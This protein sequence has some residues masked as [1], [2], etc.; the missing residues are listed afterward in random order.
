M[1]L[2]VHSVFKVAVLSIFWLI[3]PPLF[4]VF[5]IIWK[6]P[7]LL[8]RIVLTIVAPLSLIAF[9]IGIFGVTQ[10]H[11]FYFERGSRTEIETK[12]GLKFPDYETVEKRHFTHEPS[13]NGD[14]SMERTIKFDTTNIQDFYKQIDLKIEATKQDATG[15]ANI[16]W[17]RNNDGT[18][19]FSHFDLNDPDDQTLEIKIDKK[20]K[21]VTITYGRM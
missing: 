12:T 20:Q 16:S 7:K 13:F 8:M 10:L 14:F 11:Y 9:A 3:F 15:S 18:Y 2:Q 6:M 4:L 19:Y 21:V 1:K 5:S 17:S